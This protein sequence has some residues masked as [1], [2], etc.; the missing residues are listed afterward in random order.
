[1]STVTGSPLWN[2]IPAGGR[3]SNDLPLSS[4]TLISLRSTSTTRPVIRIVPGTV[5]TAAGG[6]AATVAGGA[7]VTTAVDGAGVTTAGGGDVS[8]P[9]GAT[10]PVL[11][12][13]CTTTYCPF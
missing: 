13:G 9:P 7:G 6:A 4:L 8:T 2:T 5:V 1:M 11:A 3:N 10:A 12:L